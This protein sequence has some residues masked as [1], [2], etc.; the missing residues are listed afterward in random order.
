MLRAARQVALK[1]DGTYDWA[2]PGLQ[3]RCRMDLE[4]DLAV[5][6]DV[7]DFAYPALSA[8]RTNSQL[9]QA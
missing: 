1:H 7:A 2:N 4:D 9:A 8:E 5:V 3:P 6:A